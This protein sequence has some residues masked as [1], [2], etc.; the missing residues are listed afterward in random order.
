M[1][2]KYLIII[3]FLIIVVFGG[4]KKQDEWLNKKA[5]KSDVIP[6]TIEDFKLLLNNTD[7]MNSSYSAYPT[8]SSDNFYITYANWLGAFANSERNAY[9][10]AKEIYEGTTSHDWD[11]S[12]QKIEFSNIVLDGLKDIPITSS[13]SND[14][15]VLRGTALFFRGLSYF[16][17]VQSF[18]KPYND[19]T[20]ASDMGV[21]LKASSD[22]NEKLFRSTIKESYDQLLGD[23]LQAEAFL[24]DFV[25]FK[26]Q[27]SK[28]AVQGTLARIY[29][30]MGN[31]E[32]ALIY[33]TRA[34]SQY[35][36]LIDFNSLNTSAAAPFPTFQIGNKEIIFYSTAINWGT[37][38]YSKL[39]VDDNLYNSY[40][41][42]D[43]RKNIFYVNNGANG[44][45]YKGNYTG[46]TSGGHFAGVATNELY[47]IKAE[48]EARLNKVSDAVNDLNTLLKNRWD[49]NL[50]YPIFST[51]DPEIA[52]KKIIDERRKE[53]PFLGGRRWEDLRR[54]NFDQRFR[55]TLTRELNGAI[56]TLPP[57][58]PRYVFAIPDIEIKLSGIPQ[59]D[60]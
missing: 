15:N 29:L 4:C 30:C 46:T 2:A 34:L 3:P 47:L 33:S 25:Q 43:L 22:I 42:G 45:A 19:A 36:A 44:I 50:V 39:R 56:Y 7:I 35:D 51:T 58:D 54:L 10:W 27:P 38:V 60:R 40:V 26:T 49:K 16:N 12:Y 18:C 17:L 21:V 20:A 9:I 59:N 8:I 41:A 5:S 24:P 32:Q 23:L 13:N 11:R 14:W 28:I 31:Y 52:L 6:R 1:K 55:K 53:I 37:M 48:S 57:Q